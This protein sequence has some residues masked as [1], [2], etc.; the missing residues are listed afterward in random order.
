MFS[1]L[2]SILREVLADEGGSATSNEHLYQRAMAGLLCEVA[3]ADHELDAR[4]EVAKTRML[5]VLL[6]IDDEKAKSLVDQAQG[7][8]AQSVS[9]YDYTD[10]LRQLEPEQRFELIKAMWEVAYADGRL[11][12]LEESV[13]RKTAELLYV[14]HPLFIKAKLDAQPK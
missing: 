10:K 4:E 7:E 2:S 11:D 12:P 8:S 3:G 5:S 14:D 1:K 13:I 9:L 6:D